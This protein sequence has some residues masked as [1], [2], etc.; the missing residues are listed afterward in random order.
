[1]V[2]DKNEWWPCSADFDDEAGWFVAARVQTDDYGF[3]KNKVLDKYRKRALV[4]ISQQF[5][6]D[7]LSSGFFVV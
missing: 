6:P 3:S 2:V 7:I 4:H 1:V 5:A